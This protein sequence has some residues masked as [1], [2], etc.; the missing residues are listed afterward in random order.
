[1]AT[2]GLTSGVATGA[3]AGTTTITVEAQGITGT[4]SLTV[5]PSGIT[6]IRLSPTT[7]TIQPNTT[8]KFTCLDQNGVDRSTLCQW[9]SSDTTNVTIASDGTATSIT[10]PRSQIQ[11]TIT[12]T[13]Q[14]DTTTLAATA[15]ATVP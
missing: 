11:V 2:I 10:T 9:S 13:L 4:A 8:Q 12:A 15:T 6:A 5:V 14:T 1:M 7:A 3:S